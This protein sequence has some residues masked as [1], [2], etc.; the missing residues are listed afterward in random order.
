VRCASATDLLFA[1]VGD[2]RKEM[3]IEALQLLGLGHPFLTT[4]CIKNKG[5]QS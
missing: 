2:V 4:T 5:R 1:I 3:M